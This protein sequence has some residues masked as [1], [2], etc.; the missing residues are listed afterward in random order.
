MV[1]VLTCALHQ[2]APPLCG[3]RSIVSADSFRGTTVVTAQ[4]PSL[5]SLTVSHIR[6]WLLQVVDRKL[7]VVVISSG[8]W[9]SKEVNYL[10]CKIL[11]CF[12]IHR[13]TRHVQGE[14]KS[15]AGWQLG[16]VATVAVFAACLVGWTRPA[17]WDGWQA[18]P[19]LL[20][21]FTAVHS[22]PE[23][24]ERVLWITDRLSQS[25]WC[26]CIIKNHSCKKRKQK[27]FSTVQTLE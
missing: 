1:V 21:F 4:T 14:Y 7:S 8:R 16:A 24:N 20:F 5:Y 25:C 19:V 12:T 11:S 23:D 17:V 9:A 10:K 6:V 27:L 3:N 18:G 22:W 13:A 2:W 15:N 26:L